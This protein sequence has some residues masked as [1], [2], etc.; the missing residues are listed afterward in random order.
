MGSSPT[1]PTN[2]ETAKAGVGRL[3]GKSHWHAVGAND[4]TNLRE[5][6]LVGLPL[7]A[8]RTDVLTEG[9]QSTCSMVQM[10]QAPGP[11]HGSVPT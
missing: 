6:A 5:G 9:N 7:L 3:R 4:L 10:G 11:L 8:G 1:T 2:P